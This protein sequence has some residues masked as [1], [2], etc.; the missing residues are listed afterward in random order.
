MIGWRPGI[1]IEAERSIRAI[2]RARVLVARSRRTAIPSASADDYRAE[3]NAVA[4][5]H[6]FSVLDA[7]LTIRG[8]AIFHR[9]LPM[10]ATGTPIQNYV[11]EQVSRR[12]RG[13]VA[14]TV[15]FWRNALEVNIDKGAPQWSKIQEFRE[16]RNLLVHSL[17]AVRPHGDRLPASIEGRLIAIGADPTKFVGRVPTSDSDFDD[18]AAWI[19]AA[20]VWI[21]KERP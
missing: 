12:F 1:S 13:A 7:Y 10:R 3:L 14:G 16:L 6:A 9:D 17:G 8:D 11:H 15:D 20:I 18:L 19:E 5:V 2:H 21:D 4:I